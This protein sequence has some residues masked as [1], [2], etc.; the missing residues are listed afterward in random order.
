[1][2]LQIDDSDRIAR[3]SEET[4]LPMRQVES[5]RI[6]LAGK[7]TALESP[8]GSEVQMQS[9]ARALQGLG[10][11]AQL[12]RPWQDPLVECHCLH[13]FGSLSEHQTLI[14]A[15]RRQGVSVVLSTMAWFDLANCLRKPRSW[16]GRLTAAARFAARTA[17]P[18]LPSWRRR[19]YHSVD[20][21]LPNSH[22]EARQLTRLFGVPAERIHVAPCGADPRFADADPRPF[23]DLVGVRD[24]VLCPGR[25]EPRKNQAA[26]LSAMR[27]TGVPVVILGDVAPGGEAYYETCR[28]AGGKDAVFVPRVS[29]EDPLLASAYS[30]CACLA[31]CSWYETPGLVALE[32]GLSGAP[33]VL[34]VGGCAVEY[35]GALA[36]YVRPN[37]IEGIRRA[38]TAALSQGRSPMLASHVGHYL[39]WDSAARIVCDA[40]EQ[41]LGQPVLPL[42]QPPTA[43][44]SKA[45]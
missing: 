20:A 11:D 43:A 17:C 36:H 44:R 26:L 9:L 39:T 29:H 5:P 30:A 7:L 23:I 22:A 34:P 24:F 15:A 18:W 8:G 32:A 19:M 37:D 12:W 40:Y 10:V 1:M 33:L 31:L 14:H 25:I 16:P 13:L 4:T 41:A 38:V 2:P 21:L 6:F 42:E 35:F 45:A 3:S 28:R 27:G